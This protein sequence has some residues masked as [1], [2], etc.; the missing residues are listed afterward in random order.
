M[1]EI[2]KM[3]SQESASL[4]YVKRIGSDIDGMSIYGLYFSHNPEDVFAPGWPEMPAANVDEKFLD[5]D[6]EMYEFVR[7]VRTDMTIDTAQQNTSFSMLDAKDRIFAIA[8]ENINGLDEYPEGRIVVYF[9]DSY[10]DVRAAF[11]NRGLALEK[12]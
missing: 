8:Y 5:I 7:T 12:Y 1:S 10:A 2:D 3:I 4:V 6:D 9:G 11:E